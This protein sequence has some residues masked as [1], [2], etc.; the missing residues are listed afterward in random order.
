LQRNHCADIGI[1]RIQGHG[2]LPLLARR[3]SL[4]AFCGIAISSSAAVNG[5]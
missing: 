2:V 1:H 3:F 5:R 4:S